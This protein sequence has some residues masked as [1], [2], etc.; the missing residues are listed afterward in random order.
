[1][2]ARI[3][4]LLIILVV[5]AVIYLVFYINTQ[6]S[7]KTVLY[8]IQQRFGKIPERE[9]EYEEFEAITRYFAYKQKKAPEAFYIDDITWNDLDMDSIFCMLNNTESSI[10]EGY[11]YYLLRHPEFAEETLKERETLYQYFASHTGE[12]EK[13]QLLYR[14]IGRTRKVAIMDYIERL[15]NVR[16]ESNLKHYGLIVLYLIGIV[17]MVMQNWAG[18]GVFTLALCV[19]IATYNHRKAEIEP[20][21]ITFSYI[22]KMLNNA[23]KLCKVQTPVLAPYIERVREAKMKF[24]SFRAGSI[25]LVA[26]QS[27]GGSMMDSLL[28]Y[29]RILFHVDLIKFNSMKEKMRTHYEYVEHI[30]DQM[31]FIESAI[32]VASFRESLPFYC[33]PKWREGKEAY[34]CVKDGYHPL[35]AEPV[36]NSFEETRCALITGSNAS[37][38]ST[39]LKMTAINALLSQTIHTSIASFYESSFYRIYS[40][41]ALRDSLE[42]KESYYIVEIKSLKRILTAG[43]EE[44]PILCFVDEVLRGTNTVERIAASSQILLSLAKPHIMCFAATHDIELTHLLEKAYHNYHFEEDM[45]D[46]DIIFNY[47]LKNGRATSRNAI[48]LLGIIGYDKEIIE[49]AGKTADRFI[50]SGNWSL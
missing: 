50:T 18:I 31:G 12:R 4:T 7:R 49:K 33:L 24:R 30:M 22:L 28:D 39:F 38:K 44:I 19:G 20:Y 3:K 23:D 42:T 15:D 32:A 35:I 17:M 29:V 45:V 48:K 11:L 25:I 1:M 43:K 6:M 26:D 14:D 10:G 41:M 37:G 46:D 36:A 21:I 16:S 13:L 27:I 5:L 34:I 8:M 40:S 47:I 2:D 9:Y